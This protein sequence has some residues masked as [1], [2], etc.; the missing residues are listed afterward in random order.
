MR[1]LVF[2]SVALGRLALF[3]VSAA[4]PAAVLPVKA[5]DLDFPY[6]TMEACQRKDQIV[7]EVRKRY[8]DAYESHGI[9][10]AL[11]WRNKERNLQTYYANKAAFY[12]ACERSFN[13]G[14]ARFRPQSPGSD[15]ATF[16][17]LK[18][19]P[20]SMRYVEHPLCTD[21]WFRLAARKALSG[22]VYFDAYRTDRRLPIDRQPYFPESMVI[23]CQQKTF[24]EIGRAHV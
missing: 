18:G 12:E 14:C 6:P 2:R 4:W 5:L 21:V 23:D 16:Q 22:Y 17:Q 24:K 7:D 10:N 9:F 11:F 13:E 1:F 20:D 8:R 15:W 3:A 19:I